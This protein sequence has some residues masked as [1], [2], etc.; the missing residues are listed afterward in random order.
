MKSDFA[1]TQCLPAVFSSSVVNLKLSARQSDLTF[2]CLNS[3]I[4][5]RT[6]CLQNVCRMPMDFARIRRLRSM[7]PHWWKK[8]RTCKTNIRL[9]AARSARGQLRVRK[10]MLSV[11]CLMAKNVLR[12][13]CALGTDW[14]RLHRLGPDFWKIQNENW[15]YRQN[16]KIQYFIVCWLSKIQILNF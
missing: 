9:C 2:R 8:S 15:K 10:K 7:R 5:Q 13:T 12:S 11:G 16:T 14:G 4:I 3:A 1:G 6:R